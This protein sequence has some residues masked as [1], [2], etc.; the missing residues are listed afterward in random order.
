MALIW[1]EGFDNQLG[2]ADCLDGVLTSITGSFSL[3]IGTSLISPSGPVYGR[4]VNLT[5]TAAGVAAVA[6][7]S[8]AETTVGYTHNNI[9]M[10]GLTAGDDL[11]IWWCF[12]DTVTAEPQVTVALDCATG[13]IT[14]WSGW[15]P[16]TGNGATGGGTLLGTSAAGIIAPTTFTAVEFAVKIDPSAGYVSVRVNGLPIAGASVVGVNTAPTGNTWFSQVQYG[17]TISAGSD[18]YIGAFDDFYIGDNTGST[19]NGFIGPGVTWTRFGTSDASVQF[20]P[21]AN[22]NWQEISETQM[23]SD[24]SYNYSSTVGNTDYFSSTDT[25]TTAYTPLFLKLQQASRADNVLGRNSEN[26]LVS[27]SSTFTGSSVTK[28]T[29]YTYQDDYLLNNPATSGT[30]TLGT[31]VSTE[32]GY[33]VSG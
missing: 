17:A 32:F 9:Y 20:T 26:K 19:E 18:P 2:A 21:L 33:S 11:N 24:T 30:W 1:F 31:V 29:I 28:G 22:A 6:A 14:T 5:S 12:F 4:A 7:K 23:D 3:G 27:A 16:Y 25:L 10:P 13:I 8:V 15:A